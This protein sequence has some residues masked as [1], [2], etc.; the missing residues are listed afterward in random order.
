MA[1]ADPENSINNPDSLAMFA[2]GKSGPFV[3]RRSW[4]EL[5]I[6]AIYSNIFVQDPS[7]IT[8]SRLARNSSV[9]PIMEP[10]RRIAYT[11]PPAL[12]PRLWG[13]MQGSG[14]SCGG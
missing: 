3:A 8:R 2:V 4:H 11:E 10:H 6:L 12:N 13:A 9:A 7:I 5:T 14:G 1:V